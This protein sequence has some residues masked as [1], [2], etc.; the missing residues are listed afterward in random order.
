[1]TM[2]SIYKSFVRSQRLLRAVA[3]CASA[4]VVTHSASAAVTWKNIQFGGSFSQGYLESTHNN[5]P[6]DTKDGSFDFREMSLNASTTFGTH[7]RVAGQVF[8]QT[9]GKYGDD[10]PIFDWGLLDYNFRPEI[11]VRVGRIKYPR[12]LYSDVL[13]VDVVRP[14]IFLPQSIYDSRLRDFQASFDGAM[15]Y[16]SLT[17]GQ[18]SFDY[19]VFYGDIPM[20]TDS[21]VADFFNTS[22][23]FANPPGAQ[24]LGMD[25]V[26]GAS[27]LWN[28]PVAGLRAGV[29]YSYLTDLTAEGP[30]IAVPAMT[31]SV[32]L[33]KIE[34]EGVSVEY[35]RNEWTFAAE[36]LLSK[37]AS[38]LKLPAIIAPP[39]R[40]N[41]GTKSYYASVSRRIASKFEVGTYYTETWDT[42]PSATTPLEARSR[43]DWTTAIRYDVNDH[44]LF[45]LEVHAIDGTKD[46]FNV[47]GIRNATLK[48]SMTLFAAKTTLSF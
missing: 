3:L 32:T 1:M 34:Y 14:F 19:K 42:Y 29:T 8:A 7:F 6:V 13:D 40:S 38:L 28:T 27:L 44:L 41:Y 22:S 2:T 23:L 21:G 30:F 45:K 46:M 15:I 43:R 47:P 5:Y 17:A 12:S 24:H 4:I 11:G 16:G 20:K 39:S 9:L 25:S 26:R 18:S 10:K 37:G 31:S 35:T 33:E 48:D 36:F